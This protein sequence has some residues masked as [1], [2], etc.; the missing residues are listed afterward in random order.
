M[1]QLL[2]YPETETERLSRELASLRKE[3]SNL[4]KGLFIRYGELQRRCDDAVYE[5]SSFK[6]TIGSGSCK[7]KSCNI[8]PFERSQEMST[9]LFM[10]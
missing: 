1:N 4:R 5:I 3:I 8:I 2:L 7:S 9:E 6:L 10:F